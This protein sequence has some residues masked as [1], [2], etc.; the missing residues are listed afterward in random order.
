[1][2]FFFSRL[3]WL[4]SRFVSMVIPLNSRSILTSQHRQ[5]VLQVRYFSSFIVYI[6]C[7][8]SKGWN[9]SWTFTC[10][11]SLL[12]LCIYIF[13]YLRHTL[14]TMIQHI[15]STLLLKCTNIVQVLSWKLQYG[16]RCAC[17]QRN[18]LKERT[19]LVEAKLAN[20]KWTNHQTH[21]VWCLG[22]AVSV[23]PAWSSLAVLYIVVVFWRKYCDK[24]A[25]PK[26]SQFLVFLIKF[27]SFSTSGRVF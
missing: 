16:A 9:A 26:F 19:Q 15:Y 7:L 13:W 21:T 10:W 11:L 4:F 1:M 18:I 12:I 25:Q 24:R 17:M 2:D 14:Q 3:K 20:S 23:L 22:F 27:P 8:G 5:N 6:D